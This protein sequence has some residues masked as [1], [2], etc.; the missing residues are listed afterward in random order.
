VIFYGFLVLLA[1]GLAFWLS[2][3]A[4]VKQLLRGNGTG[5]GGTER[6]DLFARQGSGPSWMSED[7]GKRTT[8][9]EPR[10]DDPR[11]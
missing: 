7:P 1:L 8:Q 4:V 3:S 10:S 5:R 11:D 2:R 9:V 6:D